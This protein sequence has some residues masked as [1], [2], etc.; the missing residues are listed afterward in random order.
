MART[1]GAK[2]ADNPSR[3]AA[4]LEKIA[5]RLGRVGATH[6][7]WRELASAAGVGLAT[8]AHHFGKRDDVIRAVLAHN[9]ER[10]RREIAVLATPDGPFPDSVRSALEHVATG[11]EHGVGEMLAVGLLEGLRH[12]ELGP[13]LVEMSLEPMIAALGAR[14]ARHQE[15][16]EIRSD[17]DPRLAALQLLSPLLLAHLHQVQLGGATG[18]A[19]DPPA[20]IDHLVRTGVASLGAPTEGRAE[21]GT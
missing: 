5:T 13:A 3:R 21:A 18:H 11:L 20:L 4:L 16:G 1:S 7:S 2:N 14:L 12:P 17:V 6:A 9:L 15:A 10:G 19:L 8:L